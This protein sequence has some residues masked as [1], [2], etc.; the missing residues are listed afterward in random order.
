M[1]NQLP[2]IFQ[3]N[4]RLLIDRL[5]SQIDDLMLCEIAAADYSQNLDANLAALK[6]M[7]DEGFVPDHHWIP[8]EVLKLI[9]WSEPINNDN[10]SH[11]M[12][13]FCCASL[14]HTAIEKDIYV[15][16]E[17]NETVII[18]LSSVNELGIGLH[19]EAGSLFSSLVKH[20]TDKGFGNEDAFLGIAILECA[21]S[22]KRVSDDEIIAL[23]KWIVDR[24]EAQDCSWAFDE[25]W[26]LRITH[27]NM[28]RESW[29]LLGRKL[30]TLDLDHR[31]AEVQE[32]VKLVGSMLMG[33]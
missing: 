8:L 13:A 3:P 28:K 27:D 23:C 24:E 12:R 30:A 11:W 14:L 29:Q 10:R 17:A 31:S 32:W 21:L 18:L 6:K 20:G 1:A 15:L 5:G 25:R 16:R 22:I 9:R 2:E 33:E 7:R 19:E 4:G 26:L